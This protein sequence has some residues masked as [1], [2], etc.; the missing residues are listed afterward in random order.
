MDWLKEYG[1]IAN[2]DIDGFEPIINVY[3]FGHSLDVTDKDILEKIIMNES[4][5]TTIYYHDK[6]AL[7]S[8]I[9]NLVKV[10]KQDNLIAKVHGEDASIEFVQQQK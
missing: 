5:K 6:K 10:I 2:M 4:T 7:G 3:I 8:Q 9:A 1:Y